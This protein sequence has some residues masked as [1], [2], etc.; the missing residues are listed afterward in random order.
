M[1]GRLHENHITTIAKVSRKT[2][3]LWLFIR[4]PLVFRITH[5]KISLP[6]DS[7]FLDE[8]VFTLKILRQ[9][10]I[11]EDC[12]RSFRHIE[13]IGGRSLHSHYFSSKSS[14]KG[15]AIVNP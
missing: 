10:P 5:Q 11:T 6:G 2:L 14:T 3:R 9:C 13:R 15:S 4:S 8:D 1:T 12:D 7:I